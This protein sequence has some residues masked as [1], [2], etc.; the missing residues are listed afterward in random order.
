MAE[1]R[2]GALSDER[3]RK[4]NDIGFLWGRW[5]HGVH[6]SNTNATLARA[7]TVPAGESVDTLSSCRLL[8]LDTRL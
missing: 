3:I 4:L 6:Q 2:K 8:R 5:D 7:N 1:Q